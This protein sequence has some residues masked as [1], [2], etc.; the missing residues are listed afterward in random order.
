MSKQPG[1]SM[2]EL[3]AMQKDEEKR[4]RNA[5]RFTVEAERSTAIT[6]LAHLTEL[7]QKERARVL[8]R[9]LKINGV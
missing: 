6:V 1:I 3:L 4:A 7:S 9:A 5:N 8:R 2:D